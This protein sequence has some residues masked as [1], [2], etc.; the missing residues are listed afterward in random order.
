MRSFVLAL[1]VTGAA[2]PAEA[3]AQSIAGEWDASMNTPGGVRTFRIVFAVKGDK[4]TGTVKRQAGDVPLTGTIKG[5]T[6]RFSYTIAYNDNALVLTVIAAVRGD[7]LQGIVD[8]GGAAQDDFSAK[9][10]SGSGRPPYWGAATPPNTKASRNALANGELSR[11]PAPSEVLLLSPSELASSTKASLRSGT[12]MIREE[13][14]V[15]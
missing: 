3:A 10:V 13:L 7:S 12:R 1:L 5:D 2:L 6:L 14:P 9:R 8:F 4:V 11:L 15:Q